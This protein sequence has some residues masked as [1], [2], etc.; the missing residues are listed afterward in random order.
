MPKTLNVRERVKVELNQLQ[1][2]AEAHRENWLP[3]LRDPHAAEKDRE[4]Y[5][6][7]VETCN[8]FIGQIELRK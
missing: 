3:Y 4:Y 2:V 5:R 7:A 1:A 6:G 8:Y